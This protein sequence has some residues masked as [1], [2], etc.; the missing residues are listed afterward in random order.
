MNKFSLAVCGGTFDLFHAGHKAF[1][2]DALKLSEKVVLGITGNA[3]VKNFKSNFNIE[4]FAV[5]KAAV[6]QFLDLVGAKDRVAIVEI[7]SAYDPYITT[8]PHYKVIVVT[9]QTEQTA[10]EINLKRQQKGA[11]KLEIVISPMKKAQDGGLISSSR[12]RD[13]QINRDGRLYL[14]PQWQN[15]SLVLP[16]ALRGELQNPWGEVF[17]EIPQNIDGAKTVVVGDATAQIFNEKKIGQFLSIVDFLIHR[18]KKFQQLSELGFDGGNTQRVTNPHGIVTP[19]LFQAVQLAFNTKNKTVILIDG[20]DDLAVLPVLL[21]APLGFTIF[22]GQPNEGLVQ[23]LVTEENKEKAYQL[24]QG[25]D[26]E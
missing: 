3:Y 7:N 12:I 1:I 6:E 16:E 24:A 23:V 22:Y 8:S 10:K 26:K 25:F 18:E 15:K 20:E 21:I 9:D 19:E 14:N 4:D 5:R 11:P 17:D 2:E 13:G